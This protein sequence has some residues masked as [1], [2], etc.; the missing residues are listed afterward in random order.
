MAIMRWDPF[1]D[2]SLMQEKMGQLFKEALYLTPAGAQEKRSSF[3]PAVDI[4]E[5]AGEVILKAELPGVL[6]ED[7]EVQI[8]EDILV[9]KGIR[10]FEKEV[11][12]ENYCRMECSYGTFRRAFALPSNIRKGEVKAGL[13]QGVLEVRIPKEKAVK[14]IRVKL[15]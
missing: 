6:K 14:Q 8:E 12:Q 4:L 5:T 11:D 7:I 10:R 1:K 3:V 13:H 2:L 9:I 15:D